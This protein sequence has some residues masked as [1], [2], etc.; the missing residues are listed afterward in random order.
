MACDGC[1]CCFSFW[2]ISCH[3]TSLAAQKVKIS[4]QWKK[5]LEILS[6]YASVPKIMIICFTVIEIWLMT[7]LIVVFHFEQFF[8]L[9]F[10][11]IPQKKKFQTNKKNAWR[12]HH[13]TH[14]YQKLW[15]DDV[16]FQRYKKVTYRGGCS[17]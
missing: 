8:S 2:A 17:T 3:F 11:L 10:P 12:C 14:V 15:L 1:N 4:R 13:S 9:L 5:L 6:F 16:Q 7:H